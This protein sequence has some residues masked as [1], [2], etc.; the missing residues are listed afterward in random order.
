MNDPI[1]EVR[2]VTRRYGA[3]QAVDA[4][5]LRLDAGEIACLLGPS[6]CG[7]STLLRMVAGL[8]PVDGGEIVIG[9]DLVSAPGRTTPPETRGVGLVFQDLALFPHLS[10]ADNIGFGIGD[11]PPAARAERIRE[12]LDRFHVAHLARAFPHTLSG[13]EQQ[14]V[15]IAR[16]LARAPALLLLDEPF[17]GLDGHLRAEVRQSVLADLRATGAAVLI[18]THDPNEAMQLAD[19]L[20]LMTDGRILQTGAPEQCYRVPVSAA[21]ARLLG[22]AITVPVRIEDGAAHGTLGMFP[23][24]GLADGAGELILRPEVLRLSPEG[25]AG[26]VEAVRFAGAGHVADIRLGALRVSCPVTGTPP[27]AGDMVGV[28]VDPAGVR[29]FPASESQG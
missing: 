3:R 18:V 23:A 28:V 20:I 6:G 13:G 19:H 16:A 7:K 5:S 27:R 12:L 2:A 8:E 25:V 11:L 14:R 29:V 22:D 10:V 26:V 17:S 15:A 1:L 9:G 21:A 4:A 24:A